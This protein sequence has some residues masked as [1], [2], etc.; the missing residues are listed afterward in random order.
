MLLSNQCLDELVC[1]QRNFEEPIPG[2]RGTGR[3]SMDYCIKPPIE[4]SVQEAEEM[5]TMSPTVAA[6]M[7]VTEMIV[8]LETVGDNVDLALGLCQGDCDTDGKS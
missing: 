5:V 6:T 8:A 1:F 4:E 2:C 3:L 7:A